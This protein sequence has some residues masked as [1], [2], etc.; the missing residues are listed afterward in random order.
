MTMWCRTLS[1]EKLPTRT[2]PRVDTI[3]ERVLAS[4]V[5]QHVSLVASPS[6][7]NT[8][9][10]L[11]FAKC[12]SQFGDNSF[13]VRGCPN[14]YIFFLVQI[15]DSTMREYRFGIHFHARSKLVRRNVEKSSKFG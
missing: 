9:T 10:I 15:C 8:L 5:D 7:G 3:H 11:H 1:S 4:Q 14:G 2:I 12:L 6:E 13:E